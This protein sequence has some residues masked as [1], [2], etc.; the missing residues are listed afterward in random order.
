[1]KTR[2]K[3]KHTHTKL[4]EKGGKQ[5]ITHTQKH[6]INELTNREKNIQH[7]AVGEIYKKVKEKHRMSRQNPLKSK[8]NKLIK[9][10]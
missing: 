5:N 1:M 3:T 6:L 7:K 10:N 2:K 4:L 8:Q 9:Q